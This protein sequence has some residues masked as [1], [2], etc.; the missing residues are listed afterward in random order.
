MREQIRDRKM[1]HRIILLLFGLAC[2]LAGCGEYY[3]QQGKSFNECERDWEDCLSELEG[4]KYRRI[5]DFGLY[6]YEFMEDCMGRRGYRLVTED[7]LPLNA[8]RRDPVMWNIGLTRGRR[9]GT[10]GTREEQQLNGQNALPR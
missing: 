4:Q 1:K 5:T 3:Y 10:A 6:E 2:L 7:K 8:K 9:Q